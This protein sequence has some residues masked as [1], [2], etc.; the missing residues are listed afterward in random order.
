[1]VTLMFSAVSNKTYA[2]QYRDQL[3]LDQ[4][5][6]LVDVAARPT[7]HTE[8]IVDSLPARCRY[9]RLVTPAQ[10]VSAESP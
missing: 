7:N 6:R 10:P 5:T 4:W 2:V 3:D 1:M 9:Y 8:V